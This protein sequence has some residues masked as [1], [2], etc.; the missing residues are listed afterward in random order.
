MKR[1]WSTFVAIIILAMVAI[2]IM[3]PH[4]ELTFYKFHREYKFSQGLD[5]QGGV[6]LKYALD[7]S[8]V[9]ENQRDQAVQGVKNVME[10]RINPLGIAEPVVQTAKVG[11][12]V[13]L[14]IELPGQKDVQSAVD[15]IGKTARLTFREV[16]ESGQD[17][18]E[19]GL[20]GADLRPNGSSVG[21]NQTTSA[22]LIELAFTSEG[23]DKFESITARNVGKPLAI[24]LDDQP[25]Q[26]AN[27]QEAITGGQ[28]QISG[29]FTIKEAQDVV[30]LL[31]AGA[32][33][34]PLN[35]IEQRSIGA[36][37][38]QESVYRSLVAGLV[39]FVLVG[40]FMILYYRM[41]GVI[42]V[43]ALVLYT[44]ISLAIFKILHVTLTL[45]GIT[46]FILSIGM[47]VDA[48][49]LIFERLKEELK[50]GKS[51]RR[52]IH[53]GFDRAWSSIRDSNASSILTALI[54]YNFGSSSLIKGFSLTLIIGIIVS[55]FT[56]VTVS[57]TLLYLLMGTKLLPVKSTN[58]D[59]EPIHANEDRG[60][61]VPQGRKRLQ[62]RSARW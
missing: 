56:A 48:N 46:G 26:I 36:T 62:G 37:L 24:Y 50:E 4:G 57:R 60:V 20:T 31:N 61:G 43:I 44:T 33:P 58:E 17:F 39:G 29:S 9:E 19:T 16:D 59:K 13:A 30:R 35:L 28:A 38:G 12:D 55:L 5:L 54:L 49:I 34:V 51:F 45:A 2:A 6:H 21:Q 1:P 52:A 7:L 41:L 32:L 10:N 11:D 18:K 23:A 14:I 27:V 47:A 22:P 53:D 25:L 15:L 42:A 8:G 40:I 3:R